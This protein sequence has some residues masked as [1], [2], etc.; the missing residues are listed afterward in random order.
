MRSDPKAKGLM[1]APSNSFTYVTIAQPPPFAGR[2][3]IVVRSRTGDSAPEL[4]QVQIDAPRQLRQNGEV[5]RPFGLD[6][7]GWDVER[8]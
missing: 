7:L 6:V 1:G 8:P 3:E 4:V 2:P 5:E